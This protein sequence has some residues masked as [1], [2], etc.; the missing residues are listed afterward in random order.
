[1]NITR[2]ER[3]VASRKVQPV[4]MEPKKIPVTM[5]PPCQDVAPILKNPNKCVCTVTLPEATILDINLSGRRQWLRIQVH[6][7]D[8]DGWIDCLYK[9]LKIPRSET[10]MVSRYRTDFQGKVKVP[11]RL[12][13]PDMTPSTHRLDVGDVVKCAIS[14]LRAYEREGRHCCGE[15]HRDM[16]LVRKSKK[17]TM[18]IPYFSDDEPVYK[19]KIRKSTQYFSDGE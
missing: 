16:V 18:D 2:F 4:S 5:P 9:H 10:L 6:P 3:H 7:S 15:L 1:M 12:W 13:D 14:E 8:A 17:R 11:L 19:K